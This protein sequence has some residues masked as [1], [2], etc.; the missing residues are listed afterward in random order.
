M[1]LLLSRPSLCRRWAPEMKPSMTKGK[2]TSGLKL[3]TYKLASGFSAALKFVFF[4]WYKVKMKKEWKRRARGFKRRKFVNVSVRWGKCALKQSA[5]FQIVLDDDI[6]DGV[7]DELNVGRVGG[8]RE[9]CVDLLL[10]FPLVEILEFHSY[11]ARR[12]FVCVGT[13]NEV[14]IS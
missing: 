2:S 8:A 3:K 6:G 12:F 7:E 5:I 11:V 1:I 10:I 9:V 14:S 13:C 4:S